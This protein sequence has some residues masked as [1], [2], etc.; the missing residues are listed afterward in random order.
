MRPLKTGPSSRMKPRFISSNLLNREVLSVVDFSASADTPKA[1]HYPRFSAPVARCPFFKSG[2]S[3]GRADD[4]HMQS[5]GSEIR[6]R[7]SSGA[8]PVAR[9]RPARSDSRMLSAST[10][11]VGRWLQ[12]APGDDNLRTELV[13]SKLRYFAAVKLRLL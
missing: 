4:L 6:A 11:G 9:T 7:N 12:S 10:Q 1:I 5:Q 3:R 8:H 13:S 2:R